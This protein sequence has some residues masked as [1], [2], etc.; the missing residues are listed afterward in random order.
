[1]FGLSL[2]VGASMAVTPLAWP[3]GGFRGECLI[4]LLKDCPIANQYSP[5]LKRGVKEYEP[6]GIHFLLIFD[7]PDITPAK[8][9]KYAG[10]Y[11]FKMPMMADTAHGLAKRL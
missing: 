4:F 1:M 10:Q 8:M 7:D 3:N 6:K 11:G 2:L 5:E 9:A